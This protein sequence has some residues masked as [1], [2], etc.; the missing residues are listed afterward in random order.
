MFGMFWYMLGGI[1]EGW[2]KYILYRFIEVQT[3]FGILRGPKFE[4]GP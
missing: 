3:N 1:A 2:E 4:F